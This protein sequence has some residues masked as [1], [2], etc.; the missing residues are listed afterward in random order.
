METT[1]QGLATGLATGAVLAEAWRGPILESVHRG[2]AVICDAGG[3]VV[4]AW[5]APDLTILPRSSCK[6]LQALPLASSGLPVPPERLALACASHQGAPMHV[7][8]VEAWLADLGLADDDFQCG[9][10]MPYSDEAKAALIRAGEAPRQV[11]NNCSGKHAGFLMLGQHL[12]AGPD[13]VD[14]GHPVQRA[15]REHF[16]AA[17]GEASPRLR[18]RRLL[19]AQ[20]RVHPD[21]PGARHGALRGRHRGWRRGPRDGR[22]APGDG[23]P[24]RPGRGRGA[25]LHRADGGDV[26]GRSGGGD[27]DRRRGRVRGDPARPTGTARRWGWRSRSRTGRRALRNARSPRSCRGSAR[28]TPRIRRR[29]RAW[30]PRFATAAGS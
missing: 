15:V 26:R 17:T 23:R 5:G 16:E 28:S 1:A 20:L 8:A 2:H 27:Q 3:R 24:P 21:G 11:H 4:E 13:Y 12:G 29:G 14:P 18:H 30:R 9:A 25:R 10:H 6:M 7:A 22:A 19:G